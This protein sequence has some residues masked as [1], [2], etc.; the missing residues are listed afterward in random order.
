MRPVKMPHNA[1]GD[2]QMNA[3]NQAYANPAGIHSTHPTPMQ[4]TR[5]HTHNSTQSS[6]RP[7]AAAPCA[8]QRCAGVPPAC[9]APQ[10]RG[11]RGPWT[12][13]APRCPARR[14]DQRPSAH[15]QA[16]EGESRGLGGEG[17][18][19]THHQC[20]T[21]VRGSV[22]GGTGWARNE[23][24]HKRCKQPAV[25]RRPGCEGWTGQPHTH[26]LG[27]AHARP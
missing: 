2:F 22:E 8:L 9:R 4:H 21:A 11:G 7:C 26:C 20:A 13:H 10:L 3:G 25:P 1:N 27:R 16:T 19:S 23:T 14:S 24:S 6:A 5:T 15:T 18:V 17:G 12:A